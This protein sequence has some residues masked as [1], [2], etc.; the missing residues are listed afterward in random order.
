M[1]NTICINLGFVVPKKNHEEV[2]NILKVQNKDRQSQ[3]FYIHTLNME[4]Q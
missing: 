3:L 4:A 1:S 2:E